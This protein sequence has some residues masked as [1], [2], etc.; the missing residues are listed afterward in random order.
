M[1]FFIICLL[2]F[3]AFSNVRGQIGGERVFEFLNVPNNARLSALGGT[4]IT[5]GWDDP[6]QF[7]SNPALIN[8]SWKQQAGLSYLGYFADVSSTNLT[9][10]NELNNKGVFAFG[11]NYFNY[12]KFD[13]YDEQGA[14]L[15]EFSAKDYAFSVGYAIQFGPFSAGATAKMV[16]SDLSAFQAS[17]L[18]FDFGGTFKH[19]EKDLILGMAVKNLGFLISDFEAGRGSQLPLDV[20]LGASYKPEFMPFRF[21]VTTRNTLRSDLVYFEGNNQTSAPGFGEEVFR[22]LVFGTEILVS[23]N[24]QLRLGYNHLLRQELRLENAGGGAGLSFG[25]MFKVKRLEFAYSRA[26]YH[27]AGGSNTFQLLIN[28][29]ELIKKNKND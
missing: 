19:P 5:S 22:R 13:S 14:Y 29:S 15:G 9:Y 10:A 8:A 4:N 2:S 17:G 25:F 21:S 1:R 18:L 11:L 26:L 20:Q 24:F 3:M 23:T 27:V 28:T 6:T 12:G 7:N 16:V